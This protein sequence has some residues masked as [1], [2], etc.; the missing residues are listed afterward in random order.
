MPETI[1][2]FSKCHNI[3]KHRVLDYA[4]EKG[5]AIKQFPM[6]SALRNE[7]S[8]WAEKAQIIHAFRTG[9]RQLEQWCQMT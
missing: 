2:S 6:K 4:R 1:Q 3:E 9:E 7:W 5:I 8:S